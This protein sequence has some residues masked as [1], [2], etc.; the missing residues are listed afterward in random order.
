MTNAVFY[1]FTALSSILVLATIVI[2]PVRS[3]VS[4]CV[5]GTGTTPCRPGF[6]TCP[7]GDFPANTPQFHVKD[8][9]CGENDPNGPSFDPVHKM[10]HLHYQ[11]HV[12]L[13]GGR[14]YGHAVSKDLIHW[15][16]MPISIWNDQPY[17]S[18]AIFTGSASIVDGRVVQVYPGLCD[19]HNAGCPGGT[20]LCIAVAANPSDPLQ[21]NWTKTEYT[22]N[23]IVNATGRDPSTAWRTPSGEWRITTF[24]T[25]I[26]GSMDF[27]TWYRLGAQTDF[28]TGEC[29][30]FFPLPR[31]TSGSG[32]APAGAGTPTHVHKC[33]HG[34]KD[35]MNVGTY[36][37]G[38]P[39]VLGKFEATPGVSKDEVVC[40]AGAMYAS[41]D[42]FDPVKSRRINWGWARVPPA[43]TQTLPRE[44][45]WNPELQQLVFSPLEEQDQ[46]RGQQLTKM[47]TPTAV[48]AN[49]T[50]SLGKWPLNAGNQ[51]EIEVTFARPTVAGIFGVVVMAGPD[52]SKSGMLFYI[53]YVP[54]KTTATVGAVGMPLGP[55]G[56]GQ[57]Y[58]K[59]MPDTDLIGDDYNVTNVDYTDPKT[60]EAACDASKE[61]KAWTYVKRPP[62][63]ASCCLKSN[64]P[65]IK[66]AP[67][68]FSG[69]KDPNNI[70]P[71]SL[72]T[73]DTLRLSP[74]DKSLT[75]RVYVDNTFSEAFFQGGRVALSITTNPTEEALAAVTSTAP[76]TLQ[77]ANA[78]TVN[79]IWVS[80]EE[81]LRQHYEAEK[82]EQEK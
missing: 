65:H 20:N 58:A 22:V 23:P 40:D 34:G 15:A 70:P 3:D 49:Q 24:D 33:S 16:H 47:D 75:I 73:S 17:D 43:S 31:T 9:S 27:K 42:F 69:V 10:Y 7:P 29:P 72:G 39:K 8:A 37:P 19:T 46:L 79:S 61:C 60:C 62:K 63:V 38:A 45:T 59:F 2:Q 36:T 26:F 81:V 82:E 57:K 78:Y 4:Q 52:A 77:S 5:D 35:W 51:S 54:G 74:S 48:A 6:Q 76:V 80:P 55:G 13:H 12:G 21:T 68:M 44:V 25:Q 18:S 67:G 11:N 66:Y 50:V 41:K 14:T 53:D 32:P 56:G 28:I 30:S 64:V 71:A 1:Y